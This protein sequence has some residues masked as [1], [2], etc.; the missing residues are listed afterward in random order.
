MHI[1]TGTMPFKCG[2]CEKSFRQASQLSLHKRVHAS[3]GI[4]MS[5]PK[6]KSEEYYDDIKPIELSYE[7]N[8]KEYKLPEIKPERNIHIF[9][10]FPAQLNII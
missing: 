5:Q 10:P 4:S 1:H 9:L 6:V 7:I 8:L 3:E 2:I